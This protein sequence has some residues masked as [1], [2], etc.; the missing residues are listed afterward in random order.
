MTKNIT[1]SHLG[2]DASVQIQ[3]QYTIEVLGNVQTITCSVEGKQLP[4]WLQLRKFKMMS[5]NENNSYVPLH[6]EGNND[7]NLDTTLFIDKVYT[8]IMR[9]ENFK[10]RK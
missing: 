5:L 10:V 1:V 4:V 3:L 7:K 6:N 9:A 8:D 2:D